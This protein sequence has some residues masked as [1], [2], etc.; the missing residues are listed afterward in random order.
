M[1]LISN[2]TLDRAPGVV[3]YGRTGNPTQPKT[4]AGT[5]DTMSFIACS[6]AND[7]IAGEHPNGN[8][9][10]ASWWDKSTLTRTDLSSNISTVS[11]ISSDGTVIAGSDRGSN[12]ITD[13]VQP[14]YWNQAGSITH[15]SLTDLSTM[16]VYTG[17]EVLGISGSSI[18]FGY[19]IGASGN[20]PAY[21]SGGAL[22]PIDTNIDGKAVCGTNSVAFGYGSP[23]TG[24]NAGVAEAFQWTLT[25]PVTTT[26]LG[27]AIALYSCSSSGVPF[28]S[29]SNGSVSVPVW[30]DM[31]GPTLHYLRTSPFSFNGLEGGVY[32][33]SDGSI[34]IASMFLRGTT[35]NVFV[36]K[37]GFDSSPTIFA[38]GRQSAFGLSPDG[39]LALGSLNSF[40]PTHTAYWDISGV[41]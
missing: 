29:V 28:G 11:C 16:T 24:P 37:D 6:S 14:V 39:T 36:W 31:T 34:A 25:V 8:Y 38:N 33:S 26:L 17:G 13:P 30:W 23:R 15:L 4:A 21:W 35:S 5:S 7:V 1:A 2:W 10:L 32:C 12:I 18:F 22:F 19:V 40:S 9:S 20:V 3:G 41:T 27:G